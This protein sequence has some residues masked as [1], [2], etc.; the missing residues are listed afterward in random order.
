MTQLKSQVHQLL[1]HILSLKEH[2]LGVLL[3][4]LQVHTNGSTRG[5]L[6][7]DH[8]QE[9]PYSTRKSVDDSRTI[10]QEE[11]ISLDLSRRRQAA[12]LMLGHRLIDCIVVLK[13][14]RL[15]KFEAL[16]L[17]YFLTKPQEMYTGW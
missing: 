8:Q 13:I 9:R 1:H 5:T 6:F 2:V 15:H 4:L 16:N 12:Y 11:T 3:V 14:I 17:H 10:F 7:N